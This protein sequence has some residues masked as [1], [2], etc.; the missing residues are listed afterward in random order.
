MNESMKNNN[1]GF[2]ALLIGSW[3][4]IYLIIYYWVIFDSTLTIIKP[5]SGNGFY[6]SLVYYLPICYCVVFGYVFA[7]VVTRHKTMPEK[8]RLYKPLIAWRTVI[9]V[10]PALVAALWNLLGASAVVIFDSYPPWS[11]GSY[12]L[13]FEISCGVIAG[14]VLGSLRNMPIEKAGD[15]RTIF[16]LALKILI[17][18]AIYLLFFCLTSIGVLKTFQ[19]FYGFAN[20]GFGAYWIT[21]VYVIF[22]GLLFGVLFRVPHFSLRGRWVYRSNGTSTWVIIL[23][24][25]VVVIGFMWEFPLPNIYLPT[26]PSPRGRVS[27]IAVIWMFALGYLL[28]E[29]IEQTG[30]KGSCGSQ[31]A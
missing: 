11:D 19:G 31:M 13:N 23:V 7:L 21:A 6:L 9:W 20:Y 14:I 12:Y 22:F 10:V 24:I 25:V 2:I 28:G 8:S 15:K 5:P 3:G 16:L 17:S 4:A 29:N 27:D 26:F 30:Q 18:A 1:I